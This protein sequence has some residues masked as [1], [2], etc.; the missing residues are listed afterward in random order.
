MG[1]DPQV[2]SDKPLKVGDRVI[3]VNGP[4]VKLRGILR[5]KSGDKGTVQVRLSPRTVHCIFISLAYLQRFEGPEPP[6]DPSALIDALNRQHPIDS[7]PLPRKR[8]TKSG[9]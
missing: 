3:I 9:V 4:Y 5:R 6:E 7:S 2:D 1:N 8:S